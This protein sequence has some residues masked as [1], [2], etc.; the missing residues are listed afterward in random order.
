M[1]TSQLIIGNLSLY[2]NRAACHLKLKNFIKCV[3]DCSRALMLLDPP[4]PQNAVSRCKAH[5]RRGTAYCEL[6]LY[7]EGLKDYEDAL[8]IDPKNE[9]LRAD[10]DRI[11]QVI[12]GSSES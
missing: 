6:E 5:V 10:A 8:K 1:T 2:S 9:A 4:V 12:Q 11:R 3:E 7:V